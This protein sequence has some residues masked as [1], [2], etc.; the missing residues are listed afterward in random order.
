MRQIKTSTI[1][2]MI[3]ILF[4]VFC[5]GMLVGRQSRA[6]DFTIRTE[7][8]SDLLR[9]ATTPS[10]TQATEPTKKTEQSEVATK[11]TPSGKININT[12]TKEELMTLPGIGETIAQRI[13]DYRIAYGNF[14]STAELDMVKGIGEKTLGEILD[15]V[16]VEDENENT[17]S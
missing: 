1:L 3:V 5:V 6:N 8:T 4:A 9:T 17:G 16:T 14:K 10:T 11:T 12:A 7:K 15:L 2:W 13:I